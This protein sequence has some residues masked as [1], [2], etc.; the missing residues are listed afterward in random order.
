MEFGLRILHRLVDWLLY[1][2][3]YYVVRYRRRMVRKNLTGAFPDKSIQEI[4]LI[5]RKFYRQFCDT[6]VEAIYAYWMTEEQMKRHYVFEHADEVNRHIAK[7]GGIILMLTHLGNWEWQTSVQLWAAQGATVLNVYRRLNNQWADRLM[8]IV[9]GKWGGANVEKQR[10][11]REIISFRQADKPAIVGLLSDQK[12]RPEVT[13]TWVEFLHH[14]TGFVDGGEVLAKKFGYPVFYGYVQRVKRGYYRC[15]LRTLSDDP[16]QT[17]EG[18]ITRAYAKILEEN[19]LAQPH[20]WLWTHNR[21]KW[22]RPK[23]K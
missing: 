8:Q 4:C 18:E 13:R 20:L 21:W 23:S 22:P 2:L 14:E 5:E 1:P 6:I 7:T 3:L 11:L 19:I 17:A 10:V 16:K 15:D 9:R 12:P